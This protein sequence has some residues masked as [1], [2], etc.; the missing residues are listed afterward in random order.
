VSSLVF[1]F[2]KIATGLYL[3]CVLGLL[4]SL[5][6]LVIA[7]RGLWAAEFELER[8]S[9]LRRQASAITWTFGLIE[10]ALAIFAIANVVAPT[11]RNDLLSGAGAAANPVVDEPMMT[12]TFG[13]NGIVLN[14]K[15]TPVS[16][17]SIEAMM[18][19]VTA[20]AAAGDNTGPRIV[21]S[22]TIAPSPVG[23]IR[24]VNSTPVG[25]SSADAWLEVPANGQV[26]FD[27]VTVIGT[28]KTS[29]FAFYK[30]EISGPSTGNTF[31]PYGGDKSSPVPTKGILGQLPLSSFQQGQYLFRLTV[32]DNTSTLRASC[33]VTVILEPAPPTATPPGAAG[34]VSP[35]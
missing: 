26:L 16:G 22:A 18:A 4:L 8:E 35:K 33:M 14:D 13:A 20:R 32:F 25:C 29:N 31:A 23:T 21:P 11:L 15:G 10:V 3:I 27:S 28:A 30:F 24:P 2:E 7:R 12:S 17:N 1:F 6:S 34:A 5:R 9:A 19:S